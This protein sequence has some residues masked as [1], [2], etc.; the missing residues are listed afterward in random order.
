MSRRR[1][2]QRRARRQDL[3]MMPRETDDCLGAS[4]GA[5]AGPRARFPLVPMS[6]NRAPKSD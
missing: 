4:L 6:S 1:I 3:Q 5:A 2:A